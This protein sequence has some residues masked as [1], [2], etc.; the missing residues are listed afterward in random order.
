MSDVLPRSVFSRVPSTVQLPALEGRILALW[1]K[2]DAFRESNRRRAAAGGPE[3]VFYDGPPFATGTPHYGHLLAGT[4]KDIVPRYW[5]MRGFQ[6]ERR[7]GWDCHGLPIENLAQQALGWSG[8]AEIRAKGVAAFNEQCRTMVQTYVGEW[9]RIVTRMGRWVDF[10]RDYKTMDR[11]F[12]ES[13]WW[14]FKRLW[15]SRDASGR[16]RVYKAHRIMPYDPVLST[17]L[18]NF[19]AGSNYKDVQDPA[20][21]VRLRLGDDGR[22][23]APTWLLAWTTTPWTLPSNLALCV[24]PAI[25]Y[26]LVRERKDGCQYL[27]AEERLAAHFAGAADYEL[28]SRLPGSDLVGLVYQPLLP[29][30]AGQPGA[31]R[32][33]GDGFVS[34]GDGTGVVHLAPAYGEDDYRVC[35]AAGIALVDPLDEECRFTAAI[36]EY[37][38]LFCKD[39]DKSIIRRLKEAGTLVRQATIVHSYPFGE[40]SDAPLIYRAIDAWYVR[41]EDLRER[42][43][44]NNGR[45]RWVP[46]AIGAN[47]FGNWLREAKDW[48]ISRNR[49]WG[50]CLPVWVNVADAGDTRCYGSVAELERDCGVKVTDLHKHHLDQLVVVRDGKTYRRTPEVLDC[51]FESGAMPY[52]SRHWMGGPSGTAA[53]EGFPAQ[54]IAEGL[55]QTR[56]WFY[57][58]LVLSTALFDRPAFENVVVNGLVLAED[59]QKMSK[60]KKNYPDPSLVLEEIG[61]DALRAYLIDSPVVRGEPLRFSEAGLRE[62]VRTVVLPYWNAISFFTTY[63]AVDGYHPESGRWPVRAPA[64]RAEI[65]RWILSVLQSLVLDVNREMEAYRL[66]NVVPRLVGFID[67]LTGWYI[68]RSRPRFWMNQDRADQGDAYATLYAVLTTF[69]K[70]LAPFMPFITEEA[71]QLLV[72]AVDPAA[73][74]SV[75]WCDYPVAETAIIDPALEGRMTVV[76]RVVSLALKLRNDQRLRVRQP[77]RALT[78]VSRDAL[79]R[80][81]VAASR[82]LI[83]DELNVKQVLESADEGAFA[84]IAVKPNFAEL[85][86]R[87]GPKLKQ[88]AA[89]LTAWGHGEVA[90]LEAGERIACAGESLSLSDVLLQR[91]ARAGAVVASDGVLTVALDTT[92]DDALRAEGIAREFVSVL[93]QARKGALF[94]VSDRIG[95]VWSAS[96]N[97]A[98]A[99][100][101][102]HP[103]HKK[104]ISDEVLATSM[105][106]QEPADGWAEADL[107]GH[108]VKFRITRM[109]P[110]GP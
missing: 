68:R 39:A 5:S 42:L 103:E 70:V 79:V 65:D 36:P 28:L 18:S 72:R 49:F 83:A 22:F 37:A 53:P 32:V 64:A 66:Y 16:P 59:G 71:H 54:F 9:R 56:G 14:V 81:A 1:E 40:R 41:V 45:I 67:D 20:I 74:A 29:Y 87:C 55:D 3:F 30:Y 110:A 69:A 91:A 108:Q 97:A 13:V 95:V 38:G 89:L 76:R 88:I 33:L 2:L 61:A 23:G 86:K 8:A 12:M 63:A 21:T 104:Y 47:R 84:D 44:A 27:L 11:D 75:H 7:F 26:A 43:I 10:E 77:L 35:R 60:S 90:R 34:T 73:P 93:Q 15:E 31:F 100:I 48:N 102:S 24:G 6:V 80:A 46:E 51:W 96:G 19:E 62:I 58:L 98:L 92:L 4:I 82:A 85:R 17:P 52:A 78:V 105:E 25:T 109:D 50:S 101:I 107:N 106:Q 94:E 57:T 99:G